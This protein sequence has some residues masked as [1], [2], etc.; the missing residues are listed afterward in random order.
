MKIG[1]EI[2]ADVYGEL[3]CGMIIGFKEH[4]GRQVISLDCGRFVYPHQIIG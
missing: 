1:Q 3:V 4:K 2:M